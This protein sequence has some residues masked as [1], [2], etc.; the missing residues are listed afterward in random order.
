MANN[1][2]TF[3]GRIMLDDKQARQTIEILAKDLERVKRQ[4]KE[5][6]NKGNDISGFDQQIKQLSASIN[7]LKTNQQAV[8][9]T[10]KNLSSASYKELSVAMRTLQKQLRSGAV[11]RNS[12]EWKRLQQKLGEVKREMNA[13]NNEGKAATSRWSRL[14]N[15]LNANWELSPKSSVLCQDW[16]WP[17]A[18]V[19][20]PTPT[21]RSRWPTCANTQA[22]PTNKSTR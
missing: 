14:V 8:N 16:L 13:I 7:A 5:A 3:N 10:L 15:T 12:E 6:L 1:T 17:Y 18:S 19:P 2:Q 11:E 4:R 20:K 9:D 21:W 22:K